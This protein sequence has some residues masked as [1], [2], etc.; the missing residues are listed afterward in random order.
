MIVTAPEAEPTTAGTNDT[1]M[2]HDVPGAMLPLQLFIWLNGAVATTLETC[3]SPVPVFCSVMFLGALVVPTACDGKDRVV[4]VTDA[5]GTVPEPLSATTCVGPMFPESSLT[6]RA[7]FTASTADG[8]NVTET[9]QFDPGVSV[10]GQSF[11]SEN[12][13]LADRLNP[14]SGLPPKLA[15]VMVWVG[16][17]VPTFCENV[18]VGGE[19]LIA[20]G[21]GLGNGI[22]VAPKT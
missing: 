9:V 1:W 13:S 17:V 2:V 7:P 5:A 6:F 14:F 12:P 21:R 22:G 3:N 20:D 11:V 10:A 15:M 4:G 16:L 19:K 18:N 8:V